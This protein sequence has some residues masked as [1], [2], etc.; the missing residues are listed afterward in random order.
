MQAAAAGQLSAEELEAQYDDAVRDTLRRFEATGSPVVTDG[1]QRKQSFATYPVAGL[2]NIAPG[3]VPIPFEDG[4]TRHLPL[5]TA[6][7][8]RYATKAS[9][10][11]DAARPFTSAQLKQAVISASVISLMYPPDGLPDYSRDAFIEDLVSE[12]TSEIKECLA[13]GAI[14]QIDFTEARLSL[15]LDPSKGLLN[16]FVDLNNACWRT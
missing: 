2:P 5:I 4:H 14:V 13:R 11:L 12:A 16:S 1:E 7:P 10:Y 6:G 15:K 8:F 9:T 3:G